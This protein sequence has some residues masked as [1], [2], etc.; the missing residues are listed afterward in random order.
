VPGGG[1]AK[2]SVSSLG[3][4]GGLLRSSGY[5][6]EKG[7][8]KRSSELRLTRERVWNGEGECVPAEGRRYMATG[9]WTTRSEHLCDF[10]IGAQCGLARVGG[11]APRWFFPQPQRTS[12]SISPVSVQRCTGH[13]E[14]GPLCERSTAFYCCITARLQVPL[15][16]S[17]RWLGSLHK[18][19]CRAIATA[20]LKLIIPRLPQTCFNAPALSRIADVLALKRTR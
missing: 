13:V 8:A 3:W 17:P 11:Q 6:K 10:E 9:R 2:L 5:P 19:L 1:A 16:P 20:V 18:Y 4:W 12:A 7:K 15:S 14:F